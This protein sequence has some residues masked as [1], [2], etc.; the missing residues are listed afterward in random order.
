MPGAGQLL[1]ELGK[2]LRCAPK[3]RALSFWE[4]CMCLNRSTTLR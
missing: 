4:A 3:L 1:R 2:A